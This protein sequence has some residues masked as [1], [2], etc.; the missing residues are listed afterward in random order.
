MVWRIFHQFE[1]SFFWSVSVTI[2]KPIEKLKGIVNSLGMFLYNTKKRIRMPFVGSQF[3]IAQRLFT[4][5]QNVRL[6]I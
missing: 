2:I 4:H 6:A 1:Q 5:D 3:F